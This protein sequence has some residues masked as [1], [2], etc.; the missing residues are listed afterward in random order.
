MPPTNLER[1]EEYVL[2]LDLGARAA[3]AEKLL[4]SLEDLSEEENEQQLW[5]AECKRRKEE[6]ARGEV[7]LQDG[8]EVLS[9]LEAELR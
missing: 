9:R 2:K 3:L 5:L 4:Q 1:L 6:I 7:T 8:E